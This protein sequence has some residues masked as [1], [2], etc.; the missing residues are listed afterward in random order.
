[1][2]PRDDPSPKP[3]AWHDGETELALPL[4]A[5][6]GD[7]PRLQVAVEQQDPRELRLAGVPGV[8]FEGERLL[9]GDRAGDSVH[10]VLLAPGELGL[11]GRRSEARIVSIEGCWYNSGLAVWLPR[12]H[13]AS[14]GGADISISGGTPRRRFHGSV[15]RNN[16]RNNFVNPPNNAANR[17]SLVRDLLTNFRRTALTLRQRPL[18]LLLGR[19]R[20]TLQQRWEAD[21]HEGE[22]HWRRSLS[23]GALP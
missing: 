14:P 7:W 6:K 16:F 8:C 2:A 19:R 10:P 13:T 17:S 18:L 23:A 3:A 4:L 21:L 12:R 5:A 9:G 11:F 1:M 22:R 15:A 20:S